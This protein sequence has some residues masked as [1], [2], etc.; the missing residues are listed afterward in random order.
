MGRS[1]SPYATFNIEPSRRGETSVLFVTHSRASVSL[2]S[3]V[4]FAGGG[5]AIPHSALCVVATS[6]RVNPLEPINVVGE[7][8]EA[9]REVH[10]R[11]VTSARGLPFRSDRV[12]NYAPKP[13]FHFPLVFFFLSAFK[14]WF[15]VRSF[16]R[17]PFKVTLTRFFFG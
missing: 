2:D 4:Y 9:A 7:D 3:F 14:F 11:A 15:T 13:V 16:S 12:A 10:S 1:R 5:G 6:P 17:A 8:L